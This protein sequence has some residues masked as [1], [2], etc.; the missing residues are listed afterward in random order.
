MDKPGSESAIAK[1]C[2]CN[3]SMNRQGKG[4]TVNGRVVYIIDADCPLHYA[5]MNCLSQTR[6]SI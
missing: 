6:D 3:A 2:V 5:A 1:G 4:S